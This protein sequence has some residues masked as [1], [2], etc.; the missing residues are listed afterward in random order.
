MLSGLSPVCVGLHVTLNAEWDGPKW[1]P[2]LGP[3]R[4][5][6][7]VDGD[8]Y[9][10]P[11]PE[12][13]RQ[14]RARVAEMLAEIEAQLRLVREHGLRPAYIDEHMGVSWPWPELRAGI[15][16]LARRE[17]LVDAH[18]VPRSP[19]PA[20]DDI[21]KDPVTRLRAFLEAISPGTYLYVTHPGRDEEDMRQLRME[22]Q[23]TGEV[24]RERDGD[25]RALL[26]GRV[27]EICR[28]RGI[29]PITYGEAAGSGTQ[30]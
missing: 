18:T 7:L 12:V 15:A 19:M 14:R 17:G 24:A 3:E 20:L 5:P 8:G 10:W 27:R 22:G 28:E 9:F 1:G 26:D 2:V 16:A 13:A 25:R 6:S 4:V 30:R 11:S 21:G 23:A 29:V